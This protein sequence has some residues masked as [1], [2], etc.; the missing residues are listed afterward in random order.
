MVEQ[1]DSALVEFTKIIAKN[2]L[3]LR[4]AERAGMQPTPTE[5][6]SMYQRWRAQLDTLRMNLGL[7][8]AEVGDQAASAENR[9]RVAVMKIESFWDQLAAGST[10]PRPIPPQ[11]AYVL[12]QDAKF[13]VEQAGIARAIELAT[14][15]KEE[16]NKAPSANPP[17]ALAPGAPPDSASRAQPP[18]TQ[19]Q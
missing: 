18:A 7:S 1:P 2:E 19:G 3:L 11:L 5:W 15:L 16:Q 17:S 10:R 9:S 13:S 14:G 12:R 6:A 4:E 8:A